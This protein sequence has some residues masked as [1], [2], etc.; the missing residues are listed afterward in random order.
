MVQTDSVKPK[1]LILTGP[2]ASGKTNLAISAALTLGGEV[3]GCDSMQIYRGMDIGTG[4]IKAEETKG[5]PHHMIDIV[6]P[7][8]EYSV[9]QYV[10]DVKLAIRAV[11][12]KGKLPI[13][14]GGTGLYINALL[15]GMNFADSK[16][17]ATIRNRL[18]EENAAFGTAYLYTRLQK[19]D[20]SSAAAIHPNDAK[21]IIRA[22]EIYE[23]TGMPKSRAIQTLECPYAYK[24]YILAPDREVLYNKINKRVDQ[25]FEEGLCAEAERLYPYKK[26]QAMQAIGYKEI[27]AY[28]DGLC[29]IEEARERIK[30]NSRHYAKRQ[31]TFFRG[32]PYEKTFASDPNEIFNELIS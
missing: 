32:M 19:V 17:D 6:E 3:V 15:S 28:L 7:D 30:M 1:I 23:T 10:E 27:V 26:C 22:L 31:L 12:E 20:P 18:Q 11:A 29:T 5:I 8:M 13:L 14:A 9:A 21:R 16:K 4:K 25:M 24:L 2:T